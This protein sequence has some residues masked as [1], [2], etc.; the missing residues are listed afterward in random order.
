MQTNPLRPARI[1]PTV[2][3]MQKTY[4]TSLLLGLL[5]GL[6]GMLPGETNFEFLRSGQL[7]G[8]AI[9]QLPAVM[10]RD[11]I[12]LTAHAAFGPV[13]F[14]DPLNTGVEPAIFLS[15]SDGIGLGVDSPGAT[16]A[17]FDADFGNDL[18]GE[19]IVMNFLQS[20]TL[21]FDHSIFITQLG[22]G[23]LE[24]HEKFTIAT[25][26][27]TVVEIL[28][29]TPWTKGNS[30]LSTWSG[31]AI[32]ALDGLLIE[33]GTRLTFTFD[34][35]DPLDRVP[36]GD[37]NNLNAGP[38]AAIRWIKVASPATFSM[39]TPY[40]VQGG[41]AQA[42]VGVELW[43]DS[44]DVTLYWSQDPDSGW[45]GQ[46]S[47]GT[48]SPIKIEDATMTGLTPNTVWYFKFEADNGSQVVQSPVATFTWAT[49][50][51]VS[52]AGD[53]TADGLAPATALQTIDE[54]LQRIR[55]MARR[56]Q[57]E[58]PL[59]PN[60]YFSADSPHGQELQDH[61]ANLVD[62]VNIN[63][64]PGYH[65]LAD[66]IIIDKETDGNIHF[67]GIWAEGAETALRDRLEIHG[68]DSNWMNPPSTHIPIVSGGQPV[69][70][71][72]DTT[73]NG[74]PAWVAHVPEVLSDNWHFHQLFVNGRRAE[75]SRWPKEGW[76]RMEEVN[77]STRLDFRMSERDVRDIPMDSLTNLNDVQAVVLHRWVE[78]RI[79]VGSYNAGTR[80]VSL[81]PPAPQPTFDFNASHPFHQAGLAPY[82]LDNVFETMS[83][84][85]EWYL[86]RSTG[87][88]F[89]IPLPGETRESAHVVAPRLSGLFL[90]A[91]R[92]AGPAGAGQI[93]E[94]LWH[95]TFHRIA[96]M[97]TRV[98]D[99]SL[100]T[101]TGNVAANSG[102]GAI[103]YRFARVPSVKACLFGHVGEF[104]VEF[105]EETVGGILSSNTF[106]SLGFG[107]F[108]MWQ[109][110]TADDL[111]HR[112]GWGH[113]HDND[114]KGYG[115][116]WHGGNGMLVAETAFTTI[117][118][119]HIRDGYLNPLAI[120]NQNT[121]YRYGFSLMVRKNLL[122]DVGRGW[123]SDLGGIYA[124][125]KSPHSV[126]EGNVIRDIN[127]RDYQ[128]QTVY[129]DG[130]VEFWTI[131]DNWL[132]GANVGNFTLK[133]WTNDIYNNVIAFS[134]G[135]GTVERLNAE[136][137]ASSSPTFPLISR[138]APT[139]E[140]NI[141]LQAGNGYVYE[142]S[143][144]TDPG[145]QPWAVLDDNLYWNQ[146]TPIWMDVAGSTLPQF[147]AIEG[148]DLNSISMDPML[149]DPQRGD[150]RVLAGSPAISQLGFIPFDNR[151]AG[152]RGAVWDAAGAVTYTVPAPP[153]PLWMPS[154]VPGLEAWLDAADFSEDGPIHQWDT[155]TPF[156]YM[157]RQ[158]DTD[159]Q[160]VV[161]TNARN[162]LPV[163]SF[164][165]TAWMANNEHSWRARRYAGQFRDR[166]FTI[167]IAH[168][169][170]GPDQVV[171]AKG[172]AGTAGQWTIGEQANALQWNG[173]SSIGQAG[174]DF[175]VRAWRRGPASWRYYENGV[176]VAEHADNLGH[177]FNTEEILYLGRSGAGDFL[178][179][180]VGE[181]LI[182]MG[183]VSDADV[184][185]VNG[186]LMDKWLETTPPTAEIFGTEVI[187]ESVAA[188]GSAYLRTLTVHV[189]DSL[190]PQAL[191]YSLL[192]GPAWLTVAPDG[193]LGGT[194]QPG[195][196]GL[197]VFQVR[198]MN[199]LGEVHDVTLQV[200]VA[201]PNPNPSTAPASTAIQAGSGSIQLDWDPSPDAD[202]SHYRILRS[203]TLGGFMVIADPVWINTYTDT[204][205]P[206]GRQFYIIQ[207]V[208]TS[209]N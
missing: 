34:T 20:V 54:A 109:L 122:H 186:Y 176:L 13:N 138:R 75:R 185:A 53:D 69:S 157:L 56:P 150:F 66:T 146:T 64:L 71:W 48:R 143:R 41:P 131:R 197:N 116:Y 140:R 153:L 104:A 88:L 124:P 114:V 178:Q 204:W 81:L 51:Y 169:S 167:F 83:D 159:L 198:A 152:I 32:G 134:A 22:F 190:D 147:Q 188:E 90:I 16:N 63:L 139:S 47:L 11:G 180:E 65:Y 5:C 73:V 166:E 202:F 91:G 58:G 8:V 61:L 103:R 111:Q 100:H 161:Q 133:G 201:A 35:V 142:R 173:A 74:V 119:N 49:D 165:G 181:V 23:D 168:R 193:T 208:N 80:W 183:H 60:F 110:N 28:G 106:R 135:D 121:L 43:G 144:Y 86:D 31:A 89:Y 33:R 42:T 55:L 149:V 57:P 195:D 162:G 128:S 27:G 39:G 59:V 84:P 97:H 156:T 126:I 38:S 30:G 145:V 18:Q 82:Y 19:S 77:N 137:L 76:F 14:A 113:I 155:K 85:G 192:S 177:D 25:D 52:P 130:Q 170:S 87:Q 94:R 127:A 108:K 101:G 6:P 72:S 102:N 9:S 207:A 172:N 141:F 4:P 98:G 189:I 171:L 40:V 164:N 50:L 205:D 96:F 129:L 179:G 3:F 68:D 196:T 132:S 24:Q 112:T 29:T 67:K 125:G 107:A 206:G 1:S 174:T 15:E 160:P 154:D 17:G 194:P 123:L 70:G 2:S 148:Q 115:R 46:A 118:H 209:G 120:T 199:G 182:Y 200:L 187:D 45:T 78:T 184:A 92:N 117:E 12:S 99:F 95:T 79:R 62:P 7:H 105:G 203:S 36:D 163:V 158:F 151:D 136:V 10:T 191:G 26:D 175:A 37:G 44:G 93:N 21:S